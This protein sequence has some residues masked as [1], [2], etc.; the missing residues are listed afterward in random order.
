[1]HNLA[2]TLLSGAALS[3]RV[4][5]GILTYSLGCPSGPT[6]FY[7]DNYRLMD[8]ARAGKTDRFESSLTA[9][10]RTSHGQYKVRTIPD[11]SVYIDTQ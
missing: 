3:G 8:K 5:A 4:E 10:F 11:V 2:R 7:G 1:M 9:K 6:K